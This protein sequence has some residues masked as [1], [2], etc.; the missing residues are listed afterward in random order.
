VICL[1]DKRIRAKCQLDPMILDDLA[2]QKDN[3]DYPLYQQN[4]L[5]YSQI[6]SKMELLT[7]HILTIFYLENGMTGQW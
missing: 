7:E 6:T 4:R 1:A 3:E 5:K 2:E